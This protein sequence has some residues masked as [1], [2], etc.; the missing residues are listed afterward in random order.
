M[1]FKLWCIANGYGAKEVAEITGLSKQTI[2][3]YWQGER[4]PSRATE[5]ML[6]EK[7]GI[8]DGL[9]DE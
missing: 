7:L 9:F 8:P 2:Y 4:A 6:K 3:F 5:K 1:K